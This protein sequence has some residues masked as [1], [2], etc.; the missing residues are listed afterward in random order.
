MFKTRLISGIVL[1]AIALVTIIIGGPLLPG[2][3]LLISLIGMN[4]LYRAAGLEG[5]P[6]TLLTGAG[7]LGAIVFYVVM[8]L[9]DS[10]WYLPVL[11]ADLILILAVYV[12]TWPKYS[13]NQVFAAWFGLMYVAVMLSYI[14]QTRRLTDGAFTVW[15]IFLCSWGCDTCAYCVG[16]LFGKHK[17]S[18]KLSPKK[19]VEGAV[20]GVAGA[21]LLGLIYAAITGRFMSTGSAPLWEYA[22]ICA[23]GALI[24]MVGD[25][26][27]SAIKRNA[28]IKDYGKLI[29]GHG[30]ILDRF[31]SVIFTAPVIY[32]LAKL[33]MK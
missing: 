13:S 24:S 28:G 7:M 1:V 8:Y 32:L 23:V 10:T 5:S 9:T 17:M 33:L 2:V 25:L 21:A 14:F 27:A 16:M 15:L 18:P 12:F 30:G 19:S 20:G 31:D 11:L 6:L 3:L 29:P 26:A 4:E 22:L